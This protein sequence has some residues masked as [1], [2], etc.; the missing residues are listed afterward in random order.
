MLTLA[1]ND[2]LPL[3][4]VD[5]EQENSRLLDQSPKKKPQGG[6]ESDTKDAKL[7]SVVDVSRSYVSGEYTLEEEDIKRQEQKD[8]GSQKKTESLTTQKTTHN[9]NASVKSEYSSIT[10]QKI[11]SKKEVDPDERNDNLGE[12][13]IMK[14]KIVESKTS[15]GHEENL[16]SKF[17]NASAQKLSERG[18]IKD[19]D[20]VSGGS[21]HKKEVIVSRY[22]SRN[23]ELER[24]IEMSKKAKNTKKT[25]E[26]HNLKD[27]SLNKVN[28]EKRNSKVIPK[29]EEQHSTSLN[30]EKQQYLKQE[31]GKM[32]SN[33]NTWVE[34]AEDQSRAF[35]TNGGVPE[36]R[37]TSKVQ[38]NSFVNS[39][40]QKSNKNEEENN[41]NKYIWRN[42]E[43]IEKESASSLRRNQKSIQPSV[44]DYIVGVGEQEKIFMEEQREKSIEK[45]SQ[46]LINDHGKKYES[47]SNSPKTMSPQTIRYSQHMYTPP[48]SPE[49]QAYY[50][51]KEEIAKTNPIALLVPETK[52]VNIRDCNV[53]QQL[54]SP[55]KLSDCTDDYGTRNSAVSNSI[56]VSN[57]KGP[58]N[59]LNQFSNSP[60]RVSEKC[61]DQGRKEEPRTVNSIQISDPA[62]EQTTTPNRVSTDYINYAKPDKR[63]PIASSIFHQQGSIPM[64]IQDNFSMEEA[65][66]KNQYGPVYSLNQNTNPSSCIDSNVMIGHRS[67]G[68][69]AD[70]VKNKEAPRITNKSQI[71]DP[72]VNSEVDEIMKKIFGQGV[73]TKA[74]DQKAKYL[75]DKSFEAKT[76]NAN[77]LFANMNPVK[78]TNINPI[79]NFDNDHIGNAQK[80]DF[81]PK[82]NQSNYETFN[83]DGRFENIQNPDNTKWALNSL[84]INSASAV[85]RQDS[86]PD[87]NQ[88][89][90]GS[91]KKYGFPNSNPLG[92]T[93]NPDSDR[94]N[95]VTD[96]YSNAY[97]GAN[98]FWKSSTNFGG[99]QG[100]TPN[101]HMQEF[102][103]IDNQT[104]YLQPGEL[105]FRKADEIKKDIE[106]SSKIQAIT[107]IDSNAYSMAR[108]PIDNIEE[109]NREAPNGRNFQDNLRR[110][111]SA[112]SSQYTGSKVLN[113]DR[114][115]GYAE[116]PISQGYGNHIRKINIDKIYGDDSRSDD[117]NRI[118][119]K[120]VSDNFNPMKEQKLSDNNE[121]D[122]TRD[123]PIEF[124]SEG[125]HQKLKVEDELYEI[126]RLKLELLV[127]EQN[128]TG[129]KVDEI[130]DSLDT[131]IDSL[132]AQKNDQ[133]D[134]SKKEFLEKLDIIVQQRINEMTKNKLSEIHL[135]LIS[136]NKQ[137]ERSFSEINDKLDLIIQNKQIS[138]P[139]FNLSPGLVKNSDSLMQIN[140]T[141]S[142]NEYDKNRLSNPIEDQAASNNIS[143]PTPKVKFQLNQEEKGA[144]NL[145]DQILS[146]SLKTKINSRT[147]VKDKVSSDAEPSRAYQVAIQESLNFI[148]RLKTIKSGS[149]GDYIRSSEENYSKGN[150]AARIPTEN[151][152]NS[153]RR[154]TEQDRPINEK[155]KNTSLDAGFPTESSLKPSNDTKEL[156]MLVDEGFS[157][158]NSAVR[159]PTESSV[160]S[161]PKSRREERRSRDN[162]IKND[163][164]QRAP[165]GEN[166]KSELAH[167][168]A[169]PNRSFATE[170]TMDYMSVTSDSGPSKLVNTTQIKSIEFSARNQRTINQLQY[171][172]TIKEA[173]K[174]ES[175]TPKPLQQGVKSPAQQPLNHAFSTPNIKPSPV[176]SLTPTPQSRISNYFGHSPSSLEQSRLQDLKPSPL[177]VY[178]PITTPQRLYQQEAYT[179]KQAQNSS[180]GILTPKE[181]ILKSSN[182]LEEDWSRAPRGSKTPQPR[183]LKHQSFTK[184]FNRSGFEQ[185]LSGKIGDRL[186]SEGKSGEPY[187]SEAYSMRNTSNSNIR[188]ISHQQPSI[189]PKS[190]NQKRS[191]NTFGDGNVHNFDYCVVD[192][193]IIA[194]PKGEERV[195]INKNSAASRN[196]AFLKA[197]SSPLDTSK[198]L[199]VKNSSQNNYKSKEIDLYEEDD[200]FVRD[201]RNKNINGSTPSSAWKQ[202]SSPYHA[203]STRHDN[204]SD[205]TSSPLRFRREPV[206]PL[207]RVQQEGKLGTVRWRLEVE[208]EPTN[209]HLESSFNNSTYRNH[210]P[211]EMSEGI[212]STR[213]M[214]PN[215]RVEL[216]DYHQRMG[217]LSAGKDPYHQE[218]QSRYRE[219][220]QS[221]SRYY[222][223]PDLERPKNTYN[224]YNDDDSANRHV[225]NLSDKAKQ[226]FIIDS[227]MSALSAVSD[228]LGGKR[229]SDETNKSVNERSAPRMILES[230]KIPS[231]NFVNSNESIYIED[232]DQPHNR[233]K[234][235]DRLASVQR[236]NLTQ[237]TFGNHERSKSRNYY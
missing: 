203:S 16:I 8:Y 57:F 212:N 189:T 27:T 145:A 151:S 9:K 37:N 136:H 159:I 64:K 138:S 33:N 196:M 191:V 153:A 178:N 182:N 129:D 144:K 105:S 55:T 122:N 107:P 44:R 142:P 32:N 179:P 99:M 24:E 91:A 166:M 47:V 69:N 121:Y 149:L 124:D 96:P 152:A 224:L 226:N 201:P 119:A 140:E 19:D 4:S 209:P 172:S 20:Y 229:T 181:K 128:K 93:S 183:E 35:T 131:K 54:N 194:V 188:P 11:Q 40:E 34:E 208:E 133:D 23:S 160:K 180:T 79:T 70:V 51:K 46:V 143:E 217:A 102:I 43:L 41:T 130:R 71:A 158:N 117:I 150:S 83:Q 106:V 230:R 109:Q 173:K 227:K 48:E 26:K 134:S 21:Q 202:A 232:N 225:Y 78:I 147:D 162:S 219:L 216:R 81:E 101:P 56:S 18:S 116:K 187:I 174:D 176:R 168:N 127:R 17:K 76:E 167:K 85:I 156:I 222:N 12:N 184:D 86:R 175:R 236:G 193:K 72:Q 218:T 228:F 223:N 177:K 141:A 77:K 235:F 5:Q 132:F 198:N 63:I 104:N 30:N 112:D 155:P 39:N 115:F 161:D 100:N 163:Y 49:S 190:E 185:I 13:S 211:S 139:G 148:D 88:A 15:F 73:D 52:A 135:N 200:Q 171:E 169:I 84:P 2:D 6:I 113:T 90:L 103:P 233:N 215:Q 95:N 80:T 108:T 50:E 82:N 31:S 7:R 36:T 74:A 207:G 126:I 170:D 125:G 62:Y 10:S 29:V 146:S 25:L 120:R 28:Q 204:L 1:F 154:V 66:M 157:K 42:S 164:M 14:G 206:S 65:A 61:I 97:F 45:Q 205:S 3:E 197:I 94:L 67:Q 213:T 220:E 114:S 92:Q 53:S 210:I 75:E 59:G 123:A 195:L 58:D 234:S 87:E 68:I 22:S 165:T 110:G 199:N 89:Y 111:D 221:K 98:D 38:E 231:N 186:P 237:N 137:A 60:P 118:E 192:S 214:K